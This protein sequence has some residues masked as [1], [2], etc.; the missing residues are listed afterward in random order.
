MSKHSAVRA[1][2]DSL[3]DEAKKL[4]KLLEDANRGAERNAQV[5]KSLI[6]KNEGL[7]R[8]LE[9]A[10]ARAKFVHERDASPGQIAQSD[11]E[12]IQTLVVFE[13]RTPDLAAW[14]ET[15]T[16]PVS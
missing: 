10:T 9:Q 16:K 15:R 3:F 1:Q 8:A 7:E 11:F 2:I 6:E 4:R 14:L 12:L 5:A 13:D